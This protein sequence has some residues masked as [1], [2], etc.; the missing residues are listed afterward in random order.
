MADDVEGL[1]AA[2]VEACCQNNVATVKA[3][4]ADGTCDVDATKALPN[5]LEGAL[6]EARFHGGE[7]WYSARVLANDSSA[8]GTLHLE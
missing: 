7:E 4:L 1:P 8:A 5:L 6:V 3:W 2:I